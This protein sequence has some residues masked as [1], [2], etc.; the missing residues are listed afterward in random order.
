M[1]SCSVH[2][3]DGA[4]VEVA[5]TVG[6]QRLAVELT[7]DERGDVRGSTSRMRRRKVGR[8]WIET[9]WGGTF[10]A[11]DTLGGVRIPTVATV[12]WDLPDGRYV[13]FRGRVT[14]LSSS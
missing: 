3:S 4:H 7:F 5:T 14:A 8:D 9:P 6:G 1:T 11:Y 12:F 2:T 10:E 13:Y